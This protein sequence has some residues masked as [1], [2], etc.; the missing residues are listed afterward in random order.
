MQVTVDYK[1]IKGKTP[2]ELD[3]MRRKIL[4]QFLLNPPITNDN[5]MA[6]TRAELRTICYGLLREDEDTSAYPYVLMDLFLDASQQK[7][8]N[9]RVVNPLTKEEVRK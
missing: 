3:E 1:D 2:A 4:G 6:T 7:I 8:C 5:F 9:G